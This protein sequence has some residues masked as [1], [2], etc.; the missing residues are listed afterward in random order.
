MRI[1]E[2][3]A[4]AVI[5]R[6]AVALDTRARNAAQLVSAA[7]IATDRSAKFIGEQAVQLHG[8]MGMTNDY[9]VGHY[10]KRL[11]C[12]GGQFG[13]A[14]WHLE[15]LCSLESIYLPIPGPGTQA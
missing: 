7:K 10:Y 5:R 6:A 12:I 15:R 2:L 4:R 13:D 9:S 11:L 1:A 8:G 14:D 3:E